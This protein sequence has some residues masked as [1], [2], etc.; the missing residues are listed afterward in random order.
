MG[1][2]DKKYIRKI[3][4]DNEI[5]NYQTARRKLTG[6]EKYQFFII[7]LTKCTVIA[8]PGNAAEPGASS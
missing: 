3:E 1:D 2:V 5:S 7:Y 4:E 8:S 6:D